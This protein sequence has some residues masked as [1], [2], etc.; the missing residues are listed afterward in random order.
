[1]PKNIIIVGG[2]L[3][4]LSI[5]K[6]L[7]KKKNVCII[8][9]SKN[10]GGIL[11]SIKI[12]NIFFD[13]GT[14]FLRETGIK[15]L[16]KILFSKIKKKW[17]NFSILKS[18]SLFNNKTEYNQFLN[19]T[20]IK[21]S[22]IIINDLINNKLR[23]K[24]KIKNEKDRCFNDYGK[25]ITE[26]VIEPKI[27]KITGKKL[28]NLPVNFSKKFN[29][30][31]FNI[32]KDEHSKELKKNKTLDK[33]ISYK[34]NY[35]GTSGLKS[36][37]PKSGGISKFIKFFLE[38]KHRIFINEKIIKIEIKKKNVSKI[39]TNKRSFDVEK[40]FW[41]ADQKIFYNL[42]SN[43][44]L[45]KKQSSIFWNFINIKSNNK[46]KSNC[47][48]LNIFDPKTN[49]IR[50]TI[51][52]NIQKR[53]SYNAT[54]EFVSEKKKIFKPNLINKLLLKYDL[55]K[56]SDKIKIINQ[57]P[58]N[59]NYYLEKNKSLNLKIFKNVFF[60]NNNFF[61]QNNQEENLINMYKA[62]INEKK[63]S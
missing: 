57:I 53:S 49:A 41:T 16:D 14:H 28:K 48:Y 51:Y 33:I 34:Y 59:L 42:V 56:K 10:L 35:Q 3:T 1:M 40:L 44:N 54:L 26:K 25:Q 43:T 52:N 19:L 22:K 27:L 61:Q 20:E 37:Y 4:G 38:K 30:S 5:A 46:F 13:F 24:I 36:F 58:V 31:R 2:G 63:L 29:F 8:E 23:G 21:S 18:G 60:S 39:T 55:I 11:N 45:K 6:V 12:K 32:D 17:S 15:K 9:A 47:F 50:M 62:I 7:R